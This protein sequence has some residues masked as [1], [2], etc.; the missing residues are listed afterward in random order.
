[1]V[2]DMFVSLRGA[3]ACAL[4]TRLWLIVYVVCLQRVQ[5]PASLK[6]RRLSAM[7]RKLQACPKQIIYQS[8]TPTG[9]V[10][11]RS[12]SGYRR[13]SGN[14]DDEVKGY[15]IRGANLLRRGSAPSG[16]PVVQLIDA[17]CKSLRLQ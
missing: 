3:L 14:A 10:D 2:A 12:D 4:I 8:M 5:K 7:T 9:D 13:L 16:K 6:V 11:V 17:Y 1:M 15:G